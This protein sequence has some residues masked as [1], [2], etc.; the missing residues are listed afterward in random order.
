MTKIKTDKVISNK[1]LTLDIETRTINGIIIPYC[2]SIFNGTKAFS[3]YLTVNKNENEMLLAAIRSLMKHTYN[4]YK[5]YVHNLSNFDGIFI[6]RILSNIPNSILSPVMKDGKLINLKFSWLTSINQRQYYN[7]DFRDS[8]LMLPNYLRKL[9]KAFNV[10]SKGY[11]PYLFVN[12]PLINLNYEGLIPAFKYYKDLTLDDYSSYVTNNIWSLRNETIKYC[13]QDCKTLWQIIEKFNDLIY[14][15]YSLNIH[16][17][18]TLPSLA[19]GIFRGHY[20]I[21]DTIPLINGQMYSEIRKAYT[22]GHSDVYIPYGKIIHRYDV[23]SLYPFVMANKPMPI[24]TPT[25]FEGDIL[26]FMDK[27]FGIFDC[28]S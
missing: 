11:F 15:K 26:N 24:G 4:N 19:F 25:Y 28:E 10:E 12:D 20:L 7:L 13:E 22:G 6:L 18:P 23:N 8:I 17:F 14:N 1:F 16:K 2:I 21:E 9:A 5:V 3:F 27:P